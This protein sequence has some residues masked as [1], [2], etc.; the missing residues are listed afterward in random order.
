MGTELAA[1]ASYRLVYLQPDPDNGER[2]CVGLLFLDERGRATCLYDPSFQKAKCVAPGVDLDLVRF[3]FRDIELKVVQGHDLDE[4]LRD[5]SPHVVTSKPRAVTA[6]LTDSVKDHLLSRFAGVETRRATLEAREAKSAELQ[7]ANH[8]AD[9]VQ[10]IAASVSGVQIVRR[11]TLR[12]LTGVSGSSRGKRLAA[13]IYSP[14]RVLAIDGV[15]L[16][17]MNPQ[18]SVSA[19]NRIVHTFWQLRRLQNESVSPEAVLRVGLVINGVPKRDRKVREAHDYAI[20]QLRRES[21]LAVDTS[22]ASDV[23]LLRRM[24]GAAGSINA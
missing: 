2:V 14:T 23:D 17:V 11:P 20:D 10:T 21:E 16:N 4:V 9:F 8:I 5:Y 15:D 22:S 18:T 13:A 6:P 7:T 12:E 19:T 3:Y 1:P 24:V